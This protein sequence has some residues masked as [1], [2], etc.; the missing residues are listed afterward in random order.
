MLVSLQGYD[1]YAY[2]AWRLTTVP[3][4]VL[5][6][7]IEMN[8][9]LSSATTCIHGCEDMTSVYHIAITIRDVSMTATSSTVVA[10]VSIGYIDVVHTGFSA[11]CTSGSRISPCSAGFRLQTPCRA[12]VL[13]RAV[14][15]C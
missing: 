2:E 8:Y 12:R 14:V 9:H 10:H 1:Y 5:P 7:D 13:V 6:S 11:C 3:V 4:I 15:L